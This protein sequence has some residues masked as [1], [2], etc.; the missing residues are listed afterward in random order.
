MMEKG[1]LTSSEIIASV[2]DMRNA[3]NNPFIKPERRNFLEV[4]QADGRISVKKDLKT[5]AAN[6]LTG[7]I[8]FRTR[9]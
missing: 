2:G 4:L 5:Y 7:S 8:W 3:Y 1:K 6:L 9:C